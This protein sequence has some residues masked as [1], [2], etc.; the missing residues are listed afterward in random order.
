MHRGRLQVQGADVGS[1]LSWSSASTDPPTAA[2]ALVEL[3]RLRSQ[4]TTAQMLL[5]RETFERAERFIRN[6]AMSGGV[7]GPV[8]TTFNDRGLPRRCRDA[9]VDIEVVTGKAFVS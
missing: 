7:D 6:A 3:N 4:L 5:R 2:S 9:R 8:T 1:G